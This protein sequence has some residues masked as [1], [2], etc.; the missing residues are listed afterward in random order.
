MPTGS[1]YSAAAIEF[2]AVSAELRGLAATVR[3]MDTTS[4][5]QGGRLGHLAPVRLAS[6]AGQAASAAAAADAAAQECRE[7]AA[8]I[9]AYEA[10]LAAYDAA[11]ATYWAKLNSYTAVW[12]APPEEGGFLISEPLPSRPIA[13]T[14]P[15]P[16]AD[17]RR[18][19]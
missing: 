14:A 12:S 2:S 4:A 10:E 15:G 7:R 1:D 6:C 16:W 5:V 17:V 3:S 18:V 9:A 13:P 11:M 19:G 8:V